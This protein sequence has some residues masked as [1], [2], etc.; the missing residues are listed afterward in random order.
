MKA[1]ED[2]LLDAPA[3][4][5]WVCP[6]CGYTSADKRKLYYRGCGA[7]ARLCWAEP[8]NGHHLPVGVSN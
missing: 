7:H 5:L 2:E 1:K 3:G 4:Q 8:V 6:H